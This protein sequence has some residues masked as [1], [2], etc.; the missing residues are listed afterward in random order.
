[1]MIEDFAISPDGQ[2][3]N[4]TGILE[5]WVGCGWCGQVGVGVTGVGTC[6]GKSARG[7]R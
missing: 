7:A 4:L 5:W 6:L 2:D 1:M 3:M